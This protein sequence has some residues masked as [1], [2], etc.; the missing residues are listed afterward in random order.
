MGGGFSK[1]K[2]E[3][4]RARRGRRESVSAAVDFVAY[5]RVKVEKPQEAYAR[6]ANAV[7]DN[8][9][10]SALDASQ[11]QEIYDAMFEKSVAPGE[12]LINEGAEGDF[13]Y[14]VE[15]G[16]FEVFTQNNPAGPNKPVFH[17]GPGGSF[18]EL[19]L[20]Y[21]A[22]RAA[23]VRACTAATVW[24]LD[25]NTFTHVIVH[26]NRQKARLEE[27]VLLKVEALQALSDGERAAVADAVQRVEFASGK[28]ILKK[29]AAAGSLYIVESGTVRLE[30]TAPNAS[31]GAVHTLEQ[32]GCFGQYALLHKAK[33]P[34]TAVAEGDTSC[35]VLSGADFERLLGP[36]R[37]ALEQAM[38]DFNN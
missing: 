1:K 26:T 18:G 23:T 36:C 17:Y 33:Q 4:K 38:P 10:F 14:I 8:F 32:G 5:Q 35:A 25:R 19:A 13:F 11:K 29:G 12:A 24:G 37:A 27:T 15:S 6:I 16:E 22:P 3:P 30:T 7:K 28:T 2:P 21:N 9:L 20:M 34:A 31:G